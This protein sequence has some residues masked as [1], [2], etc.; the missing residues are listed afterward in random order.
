MHPN[1]RERK[2]L[3]IQ[4]VLE[5]LAQVERCLAEPLDRNRSAIEA[6]KVARDRLTVDGALPSTFGLRPVSGS[7]RPRVAHEVARSLCEVTHRSRITSTS[8]PCAWYDTS[9]SPVRRQGIVAFLLFF[10]RRES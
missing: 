7:R 3:V 1:R 2:A 4:R 5:D 9:T 8:L 10:H 6:R